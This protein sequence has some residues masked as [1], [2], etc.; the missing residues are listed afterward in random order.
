MSEDTSVAE[1]LAEFAAVN[2]KIKTLEKLKDT[3][4]TQVLIWL[5]LQN[6]EHFETDTHSVTFSMQT[7]RT[8]DKPV[9]ETFLESHNKNYDSFLKTT[10][11]EMIKIISKGETQIDEGE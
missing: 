1:L 8:L 7:R 9:L 3:L 10:S 5:K 11:H 2:D 6:L 4:R